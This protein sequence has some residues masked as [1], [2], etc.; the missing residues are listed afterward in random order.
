M[1]NVRWND[2]HGMVSITSSEY[3]QLVIIA[4]KYSELVEAV[5]KQVT[6][7][8]GVQINGN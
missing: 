7:E 6:T 3:R 1:N 2:E 5:Q 4:E 8:K